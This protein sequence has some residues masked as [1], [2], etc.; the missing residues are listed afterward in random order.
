[1]RG[2][3][4]NPEIHCDFPER[5]N[6]RL[7]DVE[8]W[9]TSW[10]WRHGLV[11]G[12]EDDVRFR[13][14]GFGELAAR[15][16][17]E[18]DFEGLAIASDWAVWLFAFD[19]LYDEERLAQPLY[20]EIRRLV[21]VGWALSP[22]VPV[23]DDPFAVSLRDLITRIMLRSGPVA[24]STFARHVLMYLLGLA[25]EVANQG[26]DHMPTVA[27]YIAMRRATGAVPSCLALI[28]ISTNRLVPSHLTHHPDVARLTRMTV[29]IVCWAND[30]R[31]CAKEV[32]RSPHPRNL[33]VVMADEYGWPLPEAMR[34]AATRVSALIED[35]AD[36]RARVMAWAPLELAGYVRGLEAWIRGNLDWSART[37]RY[38]I[39]A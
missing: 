9:T 13:L 33:P 30:V 3:D 1:M 20:A 26:D 4:L 11:T 19:D 31:S 22:E 25:S 38:S 5:V 6:P 10:R 17:P 28:P 29:D 7:D 16:Y 27:E 21:D 36:L 37:K 2:V 39:A 24:V 15:T 12:A 34:R 35:F 32:A 18:A 8:T 23:S 14:A